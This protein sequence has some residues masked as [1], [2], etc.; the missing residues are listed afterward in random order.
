MLKLKKLLNDLP[1]HNFETFRFVAEH[2]NNV[3]EKGDLNK[4]CLCS[5]V[6]LS[7]EDMGILGSHSVTNV[8]ILQG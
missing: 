6:P 4:V 3:A 1:E 8:C 5:V 2:L 7:L